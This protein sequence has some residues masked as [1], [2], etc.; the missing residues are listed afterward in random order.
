MPDWNYTI[1]SLP[2]EERMLLVALVGLNQIR[3]LHQ[4]GRIVEPG[5]VKLPDLIRAFRFVLFVFPPTT[6]VVAREIAQNSDAEMSLAVRLLRASLLISATPNNKSQCSD[7]AKQREKYTRWFWNVGGACEGCFFQQT[8]DTI[9]RGTGCHAYQSWKINDWHA[10]ATC[11]PVQL[12][13]R[14]VML[15]PKTTKFAHGGPGKVIV[16]TV[17][18]WARGRSAV[19][20]IL[21]PSP[22]EKPIGVF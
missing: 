14:S 7:R 16:V 10:S 19:P 5:L 17:G 9:E 6:T 1:L 3:W 12:G 2:R 8:V 18:E 20:E 13:G 21:K 15:H 11:G 4:D 22:K